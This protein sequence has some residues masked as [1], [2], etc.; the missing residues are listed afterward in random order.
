VILDKRL[1]CAV[2]GG[3]IGDAGVSAAP[4]DVEPGTAWQPSGLVE[5]DAGR[6][7]CE[8]RIAMAWRHLGCMSDP[9]KIA[10][11]RLVHQ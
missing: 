6:Q 9:T 4:D 3:L 11:L 8:A 5:A 2:F 1:Q 7:L 10:D